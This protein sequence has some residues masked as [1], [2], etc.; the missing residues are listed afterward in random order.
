MA[1]IY[2]VN[3]KECMVVMK[4]GYNTFA[5]RKMVE[6]LDKYLKIAQERI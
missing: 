5:S 3:V 6:L 1:S 4:R 2:V